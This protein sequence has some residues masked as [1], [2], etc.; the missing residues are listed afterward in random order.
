MRRLALVSLITAGVP[1]APAVASPVG[2]SETASSASTTADKLRPQLELACLRIPNLTI[3]TERMLQ[4]LQGD[5]DILGSLA[6]LEARK[7]SGPREPGA[8]NW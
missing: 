1:A 4:R 8:S 5:A 6:S 7:S 2:A 3:P